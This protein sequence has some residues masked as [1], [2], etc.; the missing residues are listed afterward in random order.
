MFDIMSI[1]SKFMR[2]VVSKLLSMAIKS[3]TGYKVNIDLEDLD[4]K[5]DDETAHLHISGNVDINVNDLKTFMKV[6]NEE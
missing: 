6:I 3:K 2:G 5:I 4:I 1:K